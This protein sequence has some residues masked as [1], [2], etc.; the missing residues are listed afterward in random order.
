MHSSCAQLTSMR[1]VKS[2]TQGTPDRKRCSTAAKI[3]SVAAPMRKAISHSSKWSSMRLSMM[4]LR[5]ACVVALLRRD[6][7][8]GLVGGVDG[9]LAH[10]RFHFLVHRQQRLDP[11]VAL[12]RRERI[13]HRLA[14]GLDLV[15]GLRVL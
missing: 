14:A 5:L 12:G 7:A 6:E 8:G 3:T 13:H 9:R 2:C 1:I 10:A 11:L 4:S 15:Q